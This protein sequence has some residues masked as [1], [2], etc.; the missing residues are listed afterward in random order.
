MSET[1]VPRAATPWHAADC[2]C[3]ICRPAAVEAP[4]A[5]AWRPSRTLMAIVV[6][7]V[8]T[9]VVGAFAGYRLARPA[10]L[11]CIRS[12]GTSACYTDQSG[13]GTVVHN[14]TGLNVYD[15]PAMRARVECYLEPHGVTLAGQRRCRKP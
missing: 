9:A 8:L 12:H 2:T 3:G 6:A 10:G 1:T 4:R 11:H 5:P 7:L 14:T 13:P 15:T